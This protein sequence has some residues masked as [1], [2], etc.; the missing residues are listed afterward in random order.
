MASLI[1]SLY[2]GASAIYTAQTA[3]QVTGNNISN[4]ST[5]G[6]SR[7]DA[8]ITSAASISQGGL[9]YGTGVS[10]DSIERIEDPF[11]TEQLIAQS[12]N[13]GEYNA[14]SSPLSDI[15][16]LLSI[17][18][19]SLSSDIDAFFDAWSEL[20][21]NP[22][23]TTERQQVI[24]EAGNIV[25]Q[26]NQISQQFSDI[27]TSINEDLESIVPELNDQLE[28]IASLNEAIQK[29]ELSGSDAN[30]LRDE[31]NLL[32]QQVSESVGATSYT[33]EDGMVCLQLEN[34][35]PLVVDD[36]ASTLS[37]LQVGGNTELYLTSGSSTYSLSSDNFGG[38]VKGLMDVRDE[39]IPELEND[40]D[41]LVYELA[42]AVNTAH[43]TGTDANGDA[44][45]EIF[46]LTPPTDPAASAWEGAAYS[47]TVAIADPSLIA[48][49]TTGL[50]GDNELALTIAELDETTSVNNASFTEEYGRISAKAGLYV[51]SNEQYL[52]D[53]YSLLLDTTTE[54]DSVSGVSTDEEMLKL[55]QYQ[56]GYEAASRYLSVIQEMLDT[57]INL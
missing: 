41:Y 15:E 29:A 35:L 37:T 4:A 20:A 53:S 25:Y 26:A 44:A 19:S 36:Q 11:I 3:V 52:S 34:G 22:D 45:G 42:T 23:G 24:L 16:A 2:T 46:T 21:A 14:K 47:I 10:V 7:Q 32:T 8:S 49:G 31:R 54:R 43:Q 27:T 30:T 51:S 56:T 38:E 39:V 50:A 17:D 1:T 40:I 57:L 28:Q 5:E 6:Y 48:T 55:V 9:T 13:Y 12:A 33:N 18:E